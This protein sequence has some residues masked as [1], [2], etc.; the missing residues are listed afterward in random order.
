VNGTKGLNVLG[1]RLAVVSTDALSGAVVIE[2][3]AM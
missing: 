3:G 1:D 2:A